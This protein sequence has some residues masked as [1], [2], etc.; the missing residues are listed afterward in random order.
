MS[1]VDLNPIRAG[2]AE[3]PEASDY[4]S[5][6]QTIHDYARLQTKR[7]RTKTADA[8]RVPLVPLVKSKSDT[9][10][11]A[12][13]FTTKDYLELVDWTGRAARDDKKRFISNELPPLLKRLQ[14]HP[15]HYLDL[16]KGQQR[17]L[18]RL[19]AVDHVEKLYERAQALSRKFI[20]GS[21]VCRALYVA[22]PSCH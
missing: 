10:P 16:I 20:R 12:L 21:G 18:T 19:S 4:T 3:T 22:D 11:H 2:I 5:I 7:A 13:G 6:Q 14:L 9:H 17:K 15:Q 8:K 1:Y